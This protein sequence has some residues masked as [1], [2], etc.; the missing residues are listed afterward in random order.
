MITQCV[1]H[2][3]SFKQ[4]LRE[5][6]KNGIPSLRE[7]KEKMNIC[8]KC[9]MCNPYLEF[10]FSTGQTEFAVDFLKNSDKVNDEYEMDRKK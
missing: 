6:H 3:L 1:C 9:E 8:N 2:R 7:V 4:I 5:S 10:T